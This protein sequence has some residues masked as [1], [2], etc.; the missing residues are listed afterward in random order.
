M[1]APNII[2]EPNFRM[3]TDTVQEAIDIVDKAEQII[4]N[5][6]NNVKRPDLLYWYIKADVNNKYVGHLKELLEN[7]AN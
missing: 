1:K 3:Y 2:T 7:S 4:L 6:P 5:E